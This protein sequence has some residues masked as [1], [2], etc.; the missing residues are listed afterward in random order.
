MAILDDLVSWWELNETS[1]IRYDAHSSNNLSDQNTVLYSAGKVGNAAVMRYAQ[2]EYLSMLSNS[3][4]QAGN[5]DFTWATW[6]Y[7]Y[8]TGKNLSR[9]LVGKDNS[10]AGEREYYVKYQTGT[11]R[12][13]TAVFKPT[14][15]AAFVNA[16]NLGSPAVE[17]W[18]Y[19]IAWH[20]AAGDTLN[21]QVNN[22]TVDSV[23]TGGSLQAGSDA[24]FM[25][26]RREYGTATESMEGAMDETGYWKRLL[27]STER[28][29]LYNS[30]SG[31]AYSDLGP[32]SA[33]DRHFIRPRS[34]GFVNIP[35]SETTER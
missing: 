27:T 24:V 31:R 30:G 21:I 25:L 11:D 29:W 14:D 9:I 23:G 34:R 1:G 28:T 7:L 18:Y 35:I 2:S 26:G 17:T 16:D 15:S 8:S 20:D 3:E 13:Q 5:I 22:G 33:Y 4:I 6:V 12:F 19:I 32:P 10:V